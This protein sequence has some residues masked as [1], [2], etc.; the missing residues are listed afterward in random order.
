MDNQ[1]NYRDTLN[2]TLSDKDPGAFPQRGNLPAKEPE[3]QRRWMELDIYGKS[4]RRPA[5]RGTFVLH[6]GPPYSNGDIHLGHALNKVAKDITTRFRSM[7]GYCAPYV[8]G[9]DNHGL[10][11]ENAVAKAFLAKKETPD[12]VTLRRACRDYARQWIDTQR[13]QFKRL[14]IRGDWDKPYLTMNYEFEAKIVEVFG[15][16]AEHGF[17]YRGLRPVMWSA[18]LQTALADA[19]IEYENHRSSSIYVR[20]P[21]L[22]DPNN[23]FDSK[24][25]GNERY[26]DVMG[27]AI[28]WTTT[29][30]TIPANLAI[31]A[32]PNE[33]YVFFDVD[34][35]RYVV[36]EPLLELVLKVILP[37][38]RQTGQENLKDSVPVV[39]TVLGHELEGLVF[40]HPL[41]ERESPI[42]MA[43]YVTMDAGTGLVHTAPGH[44]KEDFETGQKYGLPV[45][46]PVDESGRY[47]SE[48]GE[49]EGVS[50][51]GLRVTT[52][53]NEK[54]KDSEAN[55]ALVA[56]L[57]KSGN[58]LHHSHFEHSYPH[59]WR[60]H[61][62]LIF[63]A[64]VQWFMNIDH[65]GFRQRALDAIK[66][67]TWFP[68][69][70]VNRITTMVANRPDWC[71]SRQ[72]S[73][74]VGIPAFYCD[75][76]GEYI[77]KKETVAKVAALTRAEGSD[78]WY[79][80]S[81]A[82]ILGA[83]YHCPHCDGGVDG[84][85][86]ETDVLDVWFD[87]G[88]TNR[89]VLEDTDTWSELTWPADVYLEGGDQHRGWF[90][91]SLMLAL[92][93][94]GKPPY[95]SVVTNGW[96]LDENGEAFSKSK[97]NGV[98]PLTVI[99]QSGADVLRCW[100]TSQDFME[101]TR[102][103]ENL[104]KQIG[105]YYRRIRNTFRFL[106]N[107]LYDFNPETDAVPLQDM[108]EIDRW[109]LAKLDQLVHNAV[110]MY[111][112]Y[113]YHRVFHAALQFC[114]TELSAFYLD[115][116]KDRLY[117]SGKTWQAR[118]SAQTAMHRLAETLARL[119]APILV[120]TAEEV[121]DYL[122]I[123]NK[124]ESVHLADFP[125]AGTV[126][127][128]LL[129]RWETLLQVRDVVNKGIEEGKQSGAIGKPLESKVELTADEST[130]QAL[131]PYLPVLPAVF[132]V[133]Q[134]ALNNGRSES[135]V[136]VSVSPAEGEKCARCWLIKTDVGAHSEH[137]ALCGRCADAVTGQ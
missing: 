119:L 55:V 41:F 135:G 87:S 46:N 112:A 33:T 134:V 82:E 37:S 128:E 61:S 69:E 63:R 54:N 116:L 76:C 5:P 32:H 36:A 81:P 108:E 103:G 129:A 107:N 71:L 117:A 68:K 49:Y 7:Q 17:V 110:E 97:G 86:K 96:T 4:L 99:E 31:A 12:R 91:S 126:D 122:T 92:A 22:A 27:Y 30:W 90:N 132:V 58:L 111:E 34:D 65:Y 51:A 16:L 20:F 3:F 130:Y 83:D 104:L 59:G 115:V 84:L 133:S 93:T 72:R 125:T 19:E 124:P 105:E 26:G 118:R 6:D 73:W 48:A 113:E 75:G 39:R 74:G 66:D 35:D 24:N 1:R 120:H 131:T 29:P 102:C 53:A 89:A 56:A 9:W 11:I 136:M 28:I 25:R 127:T 15:E 121:W 94:K 109:I 88:S 101:D 38:E 44:G 42:L 114:T 40:K 45:L 21:L 98:N 8:P 18:A 14:G 106:V 70:S 137:P 77:L 50:F 52:Y 78:A 64:T 60:C 80:K 43:P 13:V 23:L 95:K 79:D 123:P 62:P 100:V 10:P 67:V 57:E 85:R 2:I 47:T